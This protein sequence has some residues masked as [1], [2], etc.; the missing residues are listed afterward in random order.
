MVVR[1]RVRKPG[2]VS[3][4]SAPAVWSLWCSGTVVQPST[5][6]RSRGRDGATVSITFCF[7]ASAAV[8]FDATRTAL[9]A[10]AALRPW[11]AARPRSEAAASLT[12][13]RRRSLP[14]FE[15]VPLIGVDEPMFVSGAMASRSAASEI[16][17]PAE[18]ARA[19]RGE[20]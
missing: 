18:A 3:V 11:L 2:F 5:L 8:R 9:S 14:M 20:T 12:T 19:P 16:Q 15:P 1:N 6:S 13:L 4:I 7:S 10:Q 17:T